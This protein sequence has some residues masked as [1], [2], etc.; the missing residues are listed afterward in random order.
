MRAHRRLAAGL[1]TVALAAGC[2]NE[3]TGGAGT[4][5]A[6]PAAATTRS[7]E[8]A[9]PVAKA[10]PAV[11]AAA[12]TAP[13][14]TAPPT[15]AA[16]QPFVSV[17]VAIG[18]TSTVV[19]APVVDTQ[20]PLDPFGMFA[21][22]SG[23]RDTVAAWSLQVSDPGQ[24]VTAVSILTG[25]NVTGPGTYD[26][27]FR[28]EFGNGAALDGTGT[29]TLDPGL[30]SGTFAA[31]DADLDG[32]FA[33][34]GAAA[35]ALAEADVEVFALVRKGAS[36]RV[37]SLAE[38]AP[39]GAC[40]TGVSV[41]GDAGVG[42]PVEL[43]IDAGTVAISVGAVDLAIDPAQTELHLDGPSGSFRAVTADGLA[44]DGAYTCS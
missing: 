16:P 27:T 38:P 30:Q 35:P 37:M 12:A 36:E 33:C 25:T 15:T 9:A 44:I 28:V 39:P 21:A 42:A 26:G 19:A 18:P 20:L 34:T 40:G 23:L 41:T 17:D 2:A 7:S 4:P 43:T 1:V 13:A 8:P 11:T 6:D 29:V 31:A 24:D 22:C 5:S 32:S 10:A 14:A 3:S